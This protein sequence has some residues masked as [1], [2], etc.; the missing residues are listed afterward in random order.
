MSL[1]EDSSRRV[2][3]RSRPGWLRPWNTIRTA[4]GFV[5]EGALLLIVLCGSASAGF[6]GG[7]K[8][9]VN[10][11]ISCRAVHGLCDQGPDKLQ[12]RF[13]SGKT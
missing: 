1:P 12:D 10:P 7:G 2:G 13:P 4:Q 3:R 6:G 8:V 5:G 9:Q 11:Q